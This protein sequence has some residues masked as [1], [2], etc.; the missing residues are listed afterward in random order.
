MASL[1]EKIR[2]EMKFGMYVMKHNYS[3]EVP[4]RVTQEDKHIVVQIVH[5]KYPTAEVG[6]LEFMGG[7]TIITF[8][9]PPHNSLPY[10]L[11]L[12]ESPLI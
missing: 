12:S 10:A 6:I 11:E 5:E 4:G 9:T 7:K 3:F 8:Y 2:R 1:E